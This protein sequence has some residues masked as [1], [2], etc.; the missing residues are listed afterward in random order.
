MRKFLLFCCLFCC[1]SLTLGTFSSCTKKTGCLVTENVHSKPGRKGQLS[2][3]R[4]KSNL[5]PKEM[6]KKKKKN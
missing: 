6:R 5:F 2:T 1:L 4:G 3:K